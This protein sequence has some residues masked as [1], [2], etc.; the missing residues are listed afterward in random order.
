MKW[1]N[2]SKKHYYN[3]LNS[4]NL[5]SLITIKKTEFIILRVSK[6]KYPCLDR[7]RAEFYQTLKN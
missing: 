5:N 3:S 6:L 2:S 4:N 1:A 7:F